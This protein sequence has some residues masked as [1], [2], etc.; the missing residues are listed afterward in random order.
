M[1]NKID[2]AQF[3]VNCPNCGEEIECDED[4]NINVF[5]VRCDKCNKT[6]DVIFECSIKTLAYEDEQSIR[7]TEESLVREE[8][9]ALVH[10]FEW[11]L[12]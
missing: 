1:T 7:E 2:L 11:S 10:K 3:T 5:P 9:G 8:A 12:P 6:F 4:K